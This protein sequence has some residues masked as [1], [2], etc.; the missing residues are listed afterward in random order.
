VKFLIDNALSHLLAEAL[1]DAGHDA[2]ENGCVAVLAEDRIRVRMLP[3][4]GAEDR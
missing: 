4:G 3:I 1:R 2:V